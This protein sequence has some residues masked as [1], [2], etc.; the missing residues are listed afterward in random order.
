M[1]KIPP[2]RA[3]NTGC[4]ESSEIYDG[5][6]LQNAKDLLR[7]VNYSVP[8]GDRMRVLAI[9]EE[10]GPLPFGDCLRIIRE[11]QPVAALASMILRGFVEVELDEAFSV[12]RRW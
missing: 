11:T 12:L 5:Y 2:S 1:S 3:R 7:Y 9:L 6:R 10:Q 8:L 4:Y